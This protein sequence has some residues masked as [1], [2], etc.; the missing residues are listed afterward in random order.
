MSLSTVYSAFFLIAG[1]PYKYAVVQLCITSG[2]RRFIVP[3]APRV[4]AKG[5]I[6]DEFTTRNSYI[7]SKGHGFKKCYFLLFKKRAGTKS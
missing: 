3:L 6:L 4:W 1:M 5:H 2:E 7:K